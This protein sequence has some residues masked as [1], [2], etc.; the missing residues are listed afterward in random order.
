[1]YNV[2]SGSSAAIAWPKPTRAL[3]MGVDIRRWGHL[4]P[5]LA[6]S[7]AMRQAN[8]RGPKVLPRVA[9]VA[10]NLDIAALSPSL[11]SATG[12]RA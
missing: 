10:F 3:S 9:A 1:M 4:H 5:A 7:R 2:C 8:L 6:I 11:Y 12:T